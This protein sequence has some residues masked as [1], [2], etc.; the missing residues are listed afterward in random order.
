[1]EQCDADS[2]K[3]PYY[4]TARD[5]SPLTI[6]GLWDE[7]KDIE[8]GEHLKSCT[9]IVTNANKLASQIHDRMPVLLQPKDFD[10]W[11]A[12]RDGTE[13]LKTAPNDYLQVWPVSRRVN[14]SRTVGDDPALIDR[15]AA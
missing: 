15:V 4:Y 2:G 3:Q 10:H 12:G 7:W 8:T 13:L 1:L 5:R 11:L 14:S 6:A 9:M